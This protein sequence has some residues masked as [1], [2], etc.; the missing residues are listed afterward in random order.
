MVLFYEPMHGLFRHETVGRFLGFWVSYICNGSARPR[1][2]KLDVPAPC[3]CAWD[4]SRLVKSIG[5][6]AYQ[7]QAWT[8]QR[9]AWFVMRQGWDRRRK[10]HPFHTFV[11][12]LCARLLP[13]GSASLTLGA[14][15]N[16]IRSVTGNILSCPMLCAASFRT[17]G[18]KDVNLHFVPNKINLTGKASVLL[19]T[20]C[21]QKTFLFATAVLW[22]MGSARNWSCSTHVV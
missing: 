20:V 22:Y 8:I 2:Q 18:L 14:A 3:A 1:R 17:D 13:V 11:C 15:T 21:Q 7:S 19:V 6:H 16:W 10:S 9:A 4:V 5:F 12:G